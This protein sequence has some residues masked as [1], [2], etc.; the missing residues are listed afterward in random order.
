MWN[1]TGEAQ[2][3]VWGG[4]MGW[5]SNQKGDKGMRGHHT[6]QRKSLIQ[7]WGEWR[8]E[9]RMWETEQRDKQKV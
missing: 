3:C 1:N 4:S 2:C 9:V 5:I 6:G 7:P 8:K